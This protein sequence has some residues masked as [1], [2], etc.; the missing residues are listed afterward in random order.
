[1]IERRPGGEAGISA[2]QCL[3]GEAIWEAAKAGRWQREL[4]Q[5]AMGVVDL[6]NPGEPSRYRWRL[7]C[8][9]P[10]VSAMPLRTGATNSA[11]EATPDVV[12][13]LEE[14]C[15]D[16]AALF[17]LEFADGFKAS[18][19]HCQGEGNVVA[20]W[21]CECSNGRF[22]LWLLRDSDGRPLL[23]TD[24]ARISGQDEPVACSCKSSNPGATLVRVPAL[25]QA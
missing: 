9:L 14:A 8:I 21:S 5:A 17:L 4:G 23:R 3:E 25:T 19:L 11:P 1:M 22:G 10:R 6:V 24:A 13:P 20:G 7:G 18:L 15:G 12:P 16:G 2:V